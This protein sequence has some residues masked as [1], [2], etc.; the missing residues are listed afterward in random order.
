MQIILKLKAE[1]NSRMF[2]MHQASFWGIYK[3]SCTKTIV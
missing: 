1:K 2:L 3:I